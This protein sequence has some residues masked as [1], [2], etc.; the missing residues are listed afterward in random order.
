[1]EIE[2]SKETDRFMLA[3]VLLKSRKKGLRVR[4]PLGGFTLTVGFE[5]S[6]KPRTGKGP[7]AS[8]RR[9]DRTRKHAATTEP[10]ASPPPPP[11][12]PEPQSLLTTNEC[13]DLWIGDGCP[14]NQD[15]VEILQRLRKLQESLQPQAT[16]YQF[17]DQFCLA[18]QSESPDIIKAV[19]AL[20]N[21]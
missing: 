14:D 7:V 11:P 4:Y 6:L 13:I 18:I 2:F 1:M 21:I 9:K 3:T 10:Q 17:L 15:R 20:A 8:P 16:E 19:W 5:P 12:P